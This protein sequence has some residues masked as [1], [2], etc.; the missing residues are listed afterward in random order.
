VA[1]SGIKQCCVPEEFDLT[2]INQY[3]TSMIFEEGDEFV[4]SGTEKPAKRGRLLYLSDKIQLCQSA[5]I[6]DK[7][8]FRA[9]VEASMRAKLWYENIL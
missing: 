3:L 9:N 8:L 6:A 7:I 2:I 5:E 1:R 4:P